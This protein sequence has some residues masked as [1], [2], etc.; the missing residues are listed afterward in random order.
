M[1]ITSGESA[2]NQC[3]GIAE[4]DHALFNGHLTPREAGFLLRGG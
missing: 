1:S 4:F 2:D 3:I